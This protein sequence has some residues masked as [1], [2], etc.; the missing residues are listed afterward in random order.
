MPRQRFVSCIC[1]CRLRSRTWPWVKS[2]TKIT[3]SLPPVA[4]LQ[5]S[6]THARSV[7]HKSIVSFLASRVEYSKQNPYT[8]PLNS[9]DE[10]QNAKIF[11]KVQRTNK[12]LIQD[13]SVGCYGANDVVKNLCM[14]IN[15]TKSLMGDTANNNEWR[16]PYDHEGS[17]VP[18]FGIIVRRQTRRAIK[19]DYM[20]SE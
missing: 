12:R 19:T 13:A 20:H 2:L 18:T 16:M 5:L 15:Y 4:S 9:F 14:P 6:H 8:R 7:F 10:T 17:R 11:L 3:W 1:S